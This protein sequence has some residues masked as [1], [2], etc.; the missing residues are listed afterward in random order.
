MNIGPYTS[1]HQ[2]HEVVSLSE[3]LR[4]I[5]VERAKY[6]AAA[7]VE[8]FA[9]NPHFLDLVLRRAG[10]PP[11]VWLKLVDLPRT[12]SGESVPP[13][14][15]AVPDG[16]DVPDVSEQ[17]SWAWQAGNV[18]TRQS[19]CAPY[20]TA[21]VR[22]PVVVRRLTKAVPD[23]VNIPDLAWRL[24]LPSGSA[25]QSLMAAVVPDG[26]DVPDLS[27][28]PSPLVDFSRREMTFATRFVHAVCHSTDLIVRPAA[29]RSAAVHVRSS[30]A[31]GHERPT[32]LTTT[33]NQLVRKQTYSAASWV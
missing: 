15:T 32:A 21:S 17:P 18:A 29:P 12:N 4:S 5:A 11:P 14:L 19:V 3:V 33:G 31:P 24:S 2:Q 28:Q 30:A 9:S 27:G 26:V 22:Q 16:V 23:S 25:R 6:A 13:F 1:R 10:I 7:C 20:D 8:H